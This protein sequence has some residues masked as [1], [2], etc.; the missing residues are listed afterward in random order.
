MRINAFHNQHAPSG[1]HVAAAGLVRAH[2]YRAHA[3]HSG[4]DDGIDA[5]PVRCAAQHF[6]QERVLAYALDGPDQKVVELQPRVRGSSGHGPLR[7]RV[8]GAGPV[9]H[10]ARAGRGEHGGK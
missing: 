5:L 7:R 10:G 9:L 6:Q 8:T 3:R 1:R 2:R 4:R